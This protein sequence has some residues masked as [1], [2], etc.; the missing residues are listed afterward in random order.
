MEFQVRYSVELK[1]L[2]CKHNPEYSQ[3]ANITCNVKVRKDKTPILNFRAT[4]AKEIKEVKVRIISI[5][6]TMN[7]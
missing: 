3:E 4:L 2:W 7:F 6:T 5:S 1:D